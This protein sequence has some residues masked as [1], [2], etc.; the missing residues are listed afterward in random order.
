MTKSNY[1]EMYL[2]ELEYAA[3]SRA[4]FDQL[5]YSD[6]VDIGKAYVKIDNGVFL[7]W[8]AEDNFLSSEFIS[9][10]LMSLIDK[11]EHA[12]EVFEDYLECYVKQN[13]IIQEDYAEFVVEARL[14]YNLHSEDPDGKYDE[15]NE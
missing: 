10:I 12:F 14:Q 2:S 1:R 6:Y 9:D 13:K 7:D 8:L 3:N 15:D 5:E 4:E 11:D